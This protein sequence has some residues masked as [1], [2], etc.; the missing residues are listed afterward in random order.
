MR[1]LETRSFRADYRRLDERERGLFR[2]AVAAM[3]DAYQRHRATEATGV[4]AWPQRL[5]IKRVKG[6]PGILELTW[7]FSGPDGRATF[8]YVEVDGEIALRWRRG[9]RHRIRERSDPADLDL[10]DV[11]ALQEPRRVEADAHARGRARG[12]DVA[13][14]ERDAR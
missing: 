13:R 4:P 9:L 14:V 5:R 3:R 8:E 1:Q 6:A 2:E 10:D 11:P 7:S 12:D